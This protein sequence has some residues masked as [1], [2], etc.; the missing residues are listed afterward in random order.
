[1][2]NLTDQS[3]WDPGVYQFAI[4][5][6]IQGGPGG[7]DNQPHQNLSDRTLWLRNRIAAA[8]IQSGQT[9]GTVDNQ[10][11]VEAIV[12]QVASVPALRLVPV[13][14]VPAT[15]TVVVLTRGQ[16]SDADG[17]GATYKWVAGS[18]AVDDGASIV[19]PASGPANGRWV[20]CGI[21]A[22]ALGGAP[23]SYYATTAQVAA[24]VAPLAPL[25]SAALTGTPTAPTPI[26]TD[27]STL[28]A[29]T[30]FV[31][32]NF[33]SHTGISIVWNG[34]PG[35][36]YKLATLPASTPSTADS[37]TVKATLNVGYAAGNDTMLEGIFGNRGGFSY[38]YNV[39]G[40]NNPA[41]SIQCFGET[42][43]TTSVYAACSTTFAFST[44]TILNAG[45]AGIAGPM[46]TLYPQPI[47]T[48]APTG[49]LVF[50]SGLPGVY[51][52]FLN[53]QSPLS[54]L[55]P[56][57]AAQTYYPLTGGTV[58]G[59]V[60]A[61]G[62]ITAYRAGGTTGVL[63]FGTS[64][65]KYLYFDGTN[66]QLLGG[67][68][69]SSGGQ[70]ATV[71]NVAAA[72]SAATSAANTY[73]NSAVTPY[74]PKSG[75]TVSGALTVNG[76]L[77]SNAGD[78]YSYRAAGTSGVIFLD[79]SGSHYV[80]WNGASYY[81][82]GGE[83]FANG[84]QLA[85]LVSPGFLGVPTAPT[86]PAADNSTTL[87]TTAFV[88]NILALAATAGTNG[89]IILGAVKV[90]WGRD[91]TSHGGGATSAV[92]FW[93]G[94]SSPAWIC[95]PVMYGQITGNFATTMSLVTLAA[96]YATFSFNNYT[97]AGEVMY[98]AIGPT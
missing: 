26:A 33:L 85:R 3:Q 31:A 21:N 86:P 69:Y 71:Q 19:A 41:C 87:A 51:P 65:S 49:V 75:G 77:T 58:N 34:N 14:L 4:T 73:T 61:A 66:F 29:N 79:S 63:Y 48:T 43:G 82:P 55:T 36:Y 94:F 6:P 15:Q 74:L 76:Q 7:I 39:F 1:M 89:E 35:V 53:V 47:A 62:D 98:I 5:D 68:V 70:L 22:A 52:P 13:P 96:G 95:I 2:T 83:V 20:L 92:N 16:N 11:L 18:I 17:F 60:S 25:D 44:I 57:V 93:T 90:I 67:G 84:Y 42:N 59:P 50:S 28:L 24:A 72:Q 27:D 23:A 8:I 91:G 45:I 12:V 32:D 30:K 38:V 78:I 9:E 46:A 40:P 81:M 37:I 64:G 88:K 56:A 97:S 80:Y 54:Y 10:Q